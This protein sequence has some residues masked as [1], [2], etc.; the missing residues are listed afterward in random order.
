MKKFLK[1]LI[2]LFCTVCMAGILSMTSFAVES[3]DYTLSAPVSDNISEMLIE[4]GYPQAY[5]NCLPEEAQ[6]MI[7]DSPDYEFS[8]ASIAYYTKEGDLLKSYDISADS[9]VP[10]SQIPDADLGI[11]LTLG[12]NQDGNVLATLAYLWFTLPGDYYE[13]D[14]GIAW[15]DSCFWSHDTYFSKIDKY[16]ARVRQL[17]GSL[18]KLQSF[19]HSEAKGKADVQERGVTW[20]ADLYKP[21]IASNKVV[22][23]YSGSGQILLIPQKS[24]FTTRLF[25]TYVHHT[26]DV[27]FTLEIPR[28][29]VNFSVPSDTPSMAVQKTYTY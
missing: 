15:D 11:T 9:I 4:S 1:R 25:A 10:L 28:F 13:D 17:D 7:A 20:C 26:S 14:I 8:G 6:R 27:S 21:S 24:S 23:S 29:G 22:E 2:A 19:T 12:K 5:L 3:V 16:S 18:G